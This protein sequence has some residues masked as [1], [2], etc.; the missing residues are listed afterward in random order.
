LT[1]RFQKLLQLVHETAAPIIVFLAVDLG[2]TLVF[3]G[4]SSPSVHIGT[5]RPVATIPLKLLELAGAG[6]AVGLV[7]SLLA[8]RIDLGLIT[9]AVAFTGLLD[10][11]HLPSLFGVEQPIRPAHSI[12]F[13]AI[14]LVG[15]G[16]VAR[17][18]Y[19]IQAIF[20]ASFFAHMA[21][22]SGVFAFFAPISFNYFSIQD[23]RIP[24]ALG[25]VAFALLAGH[26]N[27]KLR[28]RVPSQIVV[29]GVMNQ[30]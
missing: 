22:D 14:T 3:F 15:L 24:L 20:V 2:L 19:D 12:A 26:L 28:P 25:S 30:K 21:S 6:L 10:I 4:I 9:L 7:A 11:D 18:R 29:N 16:L 13:L 5:L 27:L 8:K 23:Y 1:S 17:G